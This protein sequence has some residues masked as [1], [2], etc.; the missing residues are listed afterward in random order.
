MLI[1]LDKLIGLPVETRSGQVL[2]KVVEVHISI[3]T[4]EVEQYE[5]QP[6][7]MKGLLG[8]RKLIHRRQ[9]ISITQDKIVVE[10][11]VVKEGKLQPAIDVYK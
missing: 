7:L 2:G 8:R 1:K 10:D 9:V 6:S 11:G 3:E 5:V 4:Q